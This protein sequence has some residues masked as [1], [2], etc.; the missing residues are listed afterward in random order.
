MA[1]LRLVFGVEHHNPPA[2]GTDQLSAERA[3][4][5]AEIVPFI[6]LRLRNYLGAFLFPLPVLMHQCSERAQVPIFNRSET[7]LTEIL[8]VMEILYH[9]GIVFLA[10]L[11]LL[12]QDRGSPA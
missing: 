12:T 6:E 1:Q 2:A 9:P 5:Q 11:V 8:H 4:A 7:A 3:I 10:L